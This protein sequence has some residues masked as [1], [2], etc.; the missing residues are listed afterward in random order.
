MVGAAKKLAA[1]KR[2]SGLEHRFYQI[3][4]DMAHE[5][6]KSRNRY[7]IRLRG[8][9]VIPKDNLIERSITQVRTRDQK[10]ASYQLKRQEKRAKEHNDQA[11]TKN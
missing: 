3:F 4:Y 9:D 7:Y 2:K 10:E 11:R 6:E 8:K 1:E 5:L